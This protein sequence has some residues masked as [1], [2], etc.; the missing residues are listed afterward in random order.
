PAETVSVLEKAEA[1]ALRAG[2]TLRR[3]R[4]FLRR[5]EIQISTLNVGIAIADAAS[6]IRHTAD[7]AGIAVV[8]RPIPDSLRA[9][10]DRVHLTQVLVNL[11]NNAVEALEANDASDPQIEVS[12]ARGAGGWIEFAVAD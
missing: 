10:G 1:Q 11:L 8:L 5:G 12:A 2:E 6:L 4:D 3:L 9:L 7:R